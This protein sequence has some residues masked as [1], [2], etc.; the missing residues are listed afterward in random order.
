MKKVIV[1]L[2]F[3]LPF[4]S[5][6]ATAQTEMVRTGTIETVN[7]DGETGLL[8]DSET[9]EISEYITRD[10]EFHF[11][12]SAYYISRNGEFHRDAS[13]KMVLAVGFEV[14]YMAR[15]ITDSKKSILS[16]IR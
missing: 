5:L 12:A 7:P 9:G 16:I 2:L 3:A 8:K 13:G 14:S 6:K 15:S 1:I 4:L 11:G 10:G